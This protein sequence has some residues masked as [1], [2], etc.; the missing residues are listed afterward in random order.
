MTI[1]ERLEALTM[2]L[3][4]MSHSTEANAR[5]IEANARQI[6]KLTDAVTKLVGVSNEDATA[7]RTLARIADLHEKRI[8]GLEG[9]RA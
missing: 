1:D 6:E 2:N 9:G 3:E 7:I 5:Q 4:L 8:T